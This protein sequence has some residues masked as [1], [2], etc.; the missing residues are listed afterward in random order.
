VCVFFTA[1]SNMYISKDK[2]REK[3]EN[4]FIYIFHTYKHY[5]KKGEDKKNNE[6]MF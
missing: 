1:H 6:P 4:K 2:I 5:T 3:I